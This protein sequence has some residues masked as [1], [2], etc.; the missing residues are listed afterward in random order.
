MNKILIIG[1]SCTDV[2][3]YGDCNRLNPE[4][5]T[6]VL[7][8]RYENSF[9][10]MAANV[11]KNLEMLGLKAVFLT[12]KEKIVKTR[13][14]DEKSNYILLRLD[15]DFEVDPCLIDKDIEDYELVIISDY[16]KG[17]LPQK[18]LQQ[19]LNKSKL[20]FID[21]KKPIDNWIKSASFIKINEVEFQNPKNDIRL[22]N[23]ELSKKLIITLGKKGA[24]YDK[25]LFKPK[26]EVLV[27]DV[28]GAGDA[29]LAALA[30]HYY[31]H[32]N[33]KNAID[34][35]NLCASQVVSKR[36]IAY[37]EEKLL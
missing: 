34:F 12:N 36:A 26:K 16:D 24:V 6:P 35:A 13:Y 33:I 25:E 5:P 9:P 4:A 1:E 29:F 31:L 8:E 32:K 20:S 18:I 15:K 7:N 17:F 19:I 10:G 23:T 14:I 22:M 11:L 28:A 37:P 27:R 3:I 21:T 30:G 2:F